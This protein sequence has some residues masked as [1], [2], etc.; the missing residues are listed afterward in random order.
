MGVMKRNLLVLALFMTVG[1]Q[2]NASVPLQQTT[3]PE[4]IIN[5]G[6]SSATAEEILILKNR[7]AGN[8]SEPLYD[9]S[10]NKFVRF[11][12]NIYGYLDPACDTDERIYHDIHMSPNYRDL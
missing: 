2:A 10:H 6:Y 1:I 4:Y 5:S 9:R 7:A 8:P 12:R 3:E 11:W